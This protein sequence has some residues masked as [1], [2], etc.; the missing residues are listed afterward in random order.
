[1]DTL[2]KRLEVVSERV[3]RAKADKERQE[4]HYVTARDYYNKLV[5]EEMDLSTAIEELSCL[6]QEGVIRG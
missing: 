3:S 6:Q 2:E 1:M 4:K 5:Q